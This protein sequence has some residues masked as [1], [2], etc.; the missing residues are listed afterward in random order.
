[1]IIL[2]RKLY[3]K[4]PYDKEFTATVKSIQDGCIILDQT[5]FYPFGGNQLS[6]QGILTIN[7]NDL[8]VSKVTKKNNEILHHTSSNSHKKLKVGDIAI[9]K[10][11][12]N[13]RYGLMKSHTSQHIFSAV[14][15]NRYDINTIRATL[16]FEEVHLIFSQNL[17]Y[18]QLKTALKEIN[19]ICCSKNLSIKG[20][21]IAQKEIG[22]Y[23]DKIRGALPGET[24]IRTVEI[25]GLDLVCCGGTHVKNTTEIGII[26]IL[27]FKKGREVKYYIGTNALIMLTNTNVDLVN[28]SNLLNISIKNIRDKTESNIELISNLRERNK[29]IELKNLE[30]I[31]QNPIFKIGKILIYFL[32]LETDYKLLSKNLHLF[33]E[34]TFLVMKISPKKYRFISKVQSIN[35]NSILQTFQRNYGGKGGGNPT[36][37]QCTF[38]RAPK[39]IISDLKQI[40]KE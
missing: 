40:I 14:I 30:L 18:Q 11:D 31:A 23:K 33:P 20:N 16:N 38:E 5:L 15:K 9:G 34:E 37:A 1:M 32:E 10:I 26:F 22:K 36:S 4:K 7:D 13:R 28:V 3:W 29:I 12:W 17:S 39:D 6:D 35:A 2:T 19:E 27:D 25:Q 8:I 21:I 24:Q